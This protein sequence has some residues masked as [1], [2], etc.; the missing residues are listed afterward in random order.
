MFKIILFISIL[1][2]ALMAKEE[3]KY[4]E[5][6]FDEALKKAL[7]LQVDRI[8]KSS[9]AQLTKELLDKER[10][11]KEAEEKLNKREEQIRL[12]EESLAKRIAQIESRQSKILG[13][14]DENA[15]KE[16][17]R[18]KQLVSVISNMKPAKAAE[19]LSVQDATISVKIIEQIE[20]ERASKIFN[21][22]DKEVSARL[23]KQYLNMRQ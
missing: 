16:A 8:K 10:K 22:M 14:I 17:M 15:R 5:K 21:L 13:C 9:V 12:G 4:T 3:L 6:Q 18:I 19:L 23:Q 11:L 7:D 20:P 1:S 2:G